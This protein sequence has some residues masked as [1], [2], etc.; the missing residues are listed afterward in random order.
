MHRDF[1]NTIT[2]RIYD[3]QFLWIKVNYAI[4]NKISHNSS[5]KDESDFDAGGV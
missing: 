4:I 3:A 5:E 2:G 1:L